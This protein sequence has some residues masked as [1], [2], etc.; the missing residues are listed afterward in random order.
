MIPALKFVNPVHVIEAFETLSENPTFPPDAQPIL[1]YFEDG[2][3]GP[4]QRRGR[5]TPV[6]NK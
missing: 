6:V 5:Q 2:Y 4:R 1:N 3:I